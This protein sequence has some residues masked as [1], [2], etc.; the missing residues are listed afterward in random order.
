[1]SVRNGV[2]LLIALST[3][4]LLVG[5]GSSNNSSS[6]VAP[7][8]GAFSANNM[9]G[10]YVF[11]VS[12]ADA[13][14]DGYVAA[15]TIIANGSGGITGGTIDMN[16]TALSSAVIAAPINNNGSYSVG[17][18]GRGT[19]T[20]NFTGNPFSS[21]LSFD[22][23]LQNSFHG[24]VTEFDGN[25]T[26]SG[27]LDAQTANTTP[28]G[29]YAFSLSGAIYSNDGSFATVGDFTLTG[30]SITA[31]LEDFNS[32]GV[33]STNSGAGYPLSGTV[34]AGGSSSSLSTLTTSSSFGGGTLT[35]DVYP[36][37][38]THLKLIEVDSFATLSG[39]AFT[40][41]T[42]IPTGN[43]VFTL[44]GLLAGTA[45]FAAGGL[46]VTSGASIVS[47]STEDYN[48]AG[49][50]SAQG[51]PA[52]FTGTYSGAGGRFVVNLSGFFPSTINA[53]VA[54]PSSGGIFLLE[55]D[56]GGITTG[57]AYAQTSGASF[58]ASEG[59][60]LNLSG[61]SQNGEVDDI[62]EFTASAS[63]TSCT[64]STSSGSTTVSSNVIVGVVDENS[65]TSEGIAPVGNQSLCGTYGS[66]DTT[67]VGLGYSA[68]TL[69]GG[70]LLT[71][72]TV[73][74]TIFP[75]IESDSGQIATGVFELQN[76]S[77]T[78]S[79]LAKPRGM[80]VP[81]RLVQPHGTK[82]KEKQK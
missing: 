18:D 33:A 71:A 15:G 32:G 55:T 10:T 44:D 43:L 68:D 62:A 3:L 42:S 31:G 79:S 73:D 82:Q 22:F 1:M 20:I 36:I 37:D 54:Y 51:S 30:S 6:G 14:G 29:S 45:P 34:V 21:N 64:E 81:Q 67:R 2:A 60:G 9:N 66:I 48:N 24:L 70:A 25:A 39:D 69:N 4:T 74:G 49:T 12:G 38:S 78:S 47:G 52:S 11:S 23:V 17:A 72:Y 27:T 41:A 59:Y 58:A 56:D 13:N 16:D 7:P 63:G 76:A 77:A 28:A 80:F 40:E 57:A 46:I 26:G 5:C 75:F 65:Y 53:F 8:S 35:F 19:A 61:I 50:A